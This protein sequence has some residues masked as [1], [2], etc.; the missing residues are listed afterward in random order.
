MAMLRKGL[1]RSVQAVGLLTV[2]GTASTFAYAK[3]DPIFDRTLSFWLRVAPPMF[4]YYM[5]DK[6]EYQALHEKYAPKMLKSILELGGMYVLFFSIWPVSFVSCPSIRPSVR[7]SVRTQQVAALA[8]VSVLLA[9]PQR[10][11]FSTGSRQLRA[12]A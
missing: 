5:A 12:H 6:S 7:P 1:L 8:T 4:E 3:Y 2:G 9:A 11:F 10:L